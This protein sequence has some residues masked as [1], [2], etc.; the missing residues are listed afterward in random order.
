MKPRSDFLNEVAARERG[1][2]RIRVAT[3][4][5]GVAGLATAGVVAYNLPSPAHPKTVSTVT[6]TPGTSP[7]AVRYYGDDSG[8]DD[9]GYATAAGGTAGGSTG[10]H[11]TSGGS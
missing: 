9:G 4:A 11:A 10:S 6:P 8:E 5:A 7:A 3:F 2:T 1:R